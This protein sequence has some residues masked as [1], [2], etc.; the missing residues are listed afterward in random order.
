MLSPLNFDSQS[1]YTR[2]LGKCVVF[3]CGYCL[4]CITFSIFLHYTTKEFS[5]V[6][7]WFLSMCPFYLYLFLKLHRCSHNSQH[8]SLEL[9]FCYYKSHLWWFSS[10]HCHI[11]GLILHNTSIP[12]SLFLTKDFVFCFSA[13]AIPV[14][15]R[16]LLFHFPLAQYNNIK[17]PSFDIDKIFIVMSDTNITF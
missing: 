4:S 15:L 8:P 5:T 17:Y 6:F 14:S 16:I 2:S 7:S 13:F 11:A 3:L 1:F 9:D 12:I 10:I